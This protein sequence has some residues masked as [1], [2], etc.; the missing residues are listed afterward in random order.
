MCHRVSHDGA[1]GLVGSYRCWPPCIPT[2]SSI[3]LQCFKQCRRSRLE[4]MCLIAPGFFGVCNWKLDGP[5]SKATVTTTMNSAKTYCV[6]DGLGYC[7]AT[8][9][10]HTKQHVFELWAAACTFAWAPNLVGLVG[11]SLEWMYT[12]N[13]SSWAWWVTHV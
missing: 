4:T 13:L 2:C 5:H 1:W 11:T 9:H 8:G 6:V 10:C 3:P 12:R 7:L